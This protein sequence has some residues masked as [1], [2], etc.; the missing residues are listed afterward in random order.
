ML[1]KD[2]K[3]IIPQS[4]SW[5]TYA[6]RRNPKFKLHSNRGHA[7]NAAKSLGEY[8]ILQYVDNNWIE[9]CRLEHAASRRCDVCGSEITI[10]DISYHSIWKE[11]PSLYQHFFCS[12]TCRNT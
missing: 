7:L 11:Y 3:D 9:V 8:I 5:A 12:L 6:P 2:I 4:S 1:P 10:N